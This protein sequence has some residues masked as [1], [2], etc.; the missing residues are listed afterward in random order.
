MSN[1]DH[2]PTRVGVTLG[3]TSRNGDQ[4]EFRKISL[5]LDRDLGA[6]E[7]PIDAYR[8]IKALLERMVTEFQGARP[9]TANR[10]STSDSAKAALASDS[11]KRQ[12]T[13]DFK[14]AGNGNR[15]IPP[16][17]GSK[18]APPVGAAR[19]AASKLPVL[20]ERLGARLQDLEIMEGMDGLVVK[21]RRYLEDAWA[22]I[23]EVV[24]ALGGHWQKGQTS[25][26][27]SWRIPK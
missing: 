13:A 27:G 14:P 25:R 26:D 7:N 20:Q 22:E 18:G 21:P 11:A 24:R 1:Q 19:P 4:F 5:S 15:A 9:A 6:L 8:D 2:Q 23:N 16:G 17:V 12:S 10:A 3:S